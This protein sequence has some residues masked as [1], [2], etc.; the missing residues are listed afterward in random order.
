MDKI[1]E[2]ELYDPKSIAK[3]YGEYLVELAN[4]QAKIKDMRDDFKDVSEVKND[5]GDPWTDADN[6]LLAMSDL[7]ASLITY[8]SEYSG[9]GQHE[10]D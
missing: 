1:T 2:M 9:A 10:D 7:F 8:T 3:R 4:I 6:V 5:N